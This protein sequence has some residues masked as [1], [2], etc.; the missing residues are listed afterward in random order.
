MSIEELKKIQDNAKEK[1]KR[2]LKIGLIV[3]P[4]M[5]I[6]TILSFIWVGNYRGTLN[7]MFIILYCIFF[8]FGLMSPVIFFFVWNELTVKSRKL[9]HESFKEVFVINQLNK[10]FSNL[11]YNF[12]KGLDEAKI[13][14]TRLNNIGKDFSSND[15]IKGTYNGIKF[16]QADV[17]ISDI[18]HDSNTLETIFKGRLMIFDFNKNF[19]TSFIVYSKGFK[20]GKLWNDKRLK[21][22][23]LESEEFN[24][25]FVVFAENEHDVF[26]VLTPHFMKKIEDIFQKIVYDVYFEFIDNKLYIAVNNYKDSF[27]YSLYNEIDENKIQNEILE[28]IKIITDFVDELGLDNNMFKDGF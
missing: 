23:H 3:V 14:E 16:E 17:I 1:S 10:I 24:N 5:I 13:K 15:Y 18:S 7:S 11:E 9:Y 4:I 20:T 21:R 2:I 25:K 6:I 8:M 27:E 28:D 12:D 19:K 26:Y 22:I